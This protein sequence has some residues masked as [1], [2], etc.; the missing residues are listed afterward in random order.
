M[1]RTERKNN[2]PNKNEPINI[3]EEPDL[4]NAFDSLQNIRG[5]VT[6]S[7]ENI[8]IYMTQLEG[9]FDQVEPK[10]QEEIKKEKVRLSESMKEIQFD[11]DNLDNIEKALVKACPTIKSKDKKK[12]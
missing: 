6:Q 10:K 1:G 12:K 5:K 4:V 8:E 3:C 11:L 9:V 7:K 2:K